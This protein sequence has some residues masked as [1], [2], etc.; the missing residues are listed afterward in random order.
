MDIYCPHC[1]T[2]YEVTEQEL[3]RKALCEVCNK[4]FIIM[5]A[6]SDSVKERKTITCPNCGTEYEVVDDEFGKSVQCE[7]CGGDFIIGEKQRR[8]AVESP[9]F[10]QDEV[11]TKKVPRPVFENRAITSGANHTAQDVG[12]YFSVFERK[13]YTGIIC[14][15]GFSISMVFGFATSSGAVGLFFGVISFII[16]VIYSAYMR[17]L[18]R[19][20]ESDID[21]LAR[22]MG[23]GLER[24]ALK[25]LGIDR[26]EVSL[27]DPV[28]FW[29]YRFV[30]PSVLGDT[31]DNLAEWIMGSDGRCRSSEVS[32]TILFFGEH[33]V[34]C[35]VRTASLVCSTAVRDSTEE[36]F[37]KD[38]VSVKTDSKNVP[39]RDAMG[40]EI[41]GKTFRK[42]EFVLTNAGGERRE[43]EVMNPVKAEEA[44][45][46]F[47]MLLRQKKL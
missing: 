27:M 46:A 29:G 25:K 3:G 6:R 11:T 14:A 47:R 31:A 22:A 39:L 45:K 35:Y 43:C 37:Y 15:V 32:H 42:D 28:Y 24:I 7:V 8:M 18:N 33:S 21:N 19:L 20:T 23:S 1:G 12:V 26:E 2:R 44:A 41:A 5:E 9:S 4:K 40:V 13:D 30:W 36:Y 10:T 34:Y 16:A 17:D 38:I